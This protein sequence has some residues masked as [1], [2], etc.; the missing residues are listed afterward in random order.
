MNCMKQSWIGTPGRFFLRSSWMNLGRNFWM[1]A[2][3][4]CLKKSQQK[5]LESSQKVQVYL[6]CNSLWKIIL[7]SQ[8][9]F[10]KRWFQERILELIFVDILKRVS[11]IITEGVIPDRIN[12][13]THKKFQSIFKMQFLEEFRKKSLEEFQY[14]RNFGRNFRRKN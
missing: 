2:Q 13:R 14:S 11:G 3:T 1:E 4:E 10:L 6:S 12:G 7:N 8:I 9:L 5:L